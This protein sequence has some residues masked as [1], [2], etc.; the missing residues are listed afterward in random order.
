MPYNGSGDYSAP[1]N[2]FNPAVGGTTISS[3]DWNSLLSDLETALSSVVTKDGQTVITA[4]LPMSGFKHTGVNTNSGSTSR[5]EYASG[6]TLQDGAPLDAGDTGGTSTVYTATLT[7]AITAYANKQCFRVKFNAACG[8]N[9]TI[10][11]NSV[12]AKKIYK[13]VAGTAIQLAASDVYANTIGVLRYDTALD[14]AAGG[15][16]LL[17]ITTNVTPEIPNGRLTLTSN[18]PIT[19]SSITAATSVYFTPYNGT[20]I[21]LYNGSSWSQFSLSQLTLALDSNSGHTGYQQSGKN[22]D[23]FVVNDSGTLRLGTGP[24]WSSDTSR[25]TGAGTTELTLQNGFYVNANSMTL[26]Y[27]SANGDTLTAAVGT[28][29]YVGTMR[30]SANGQT[31][32]SLSNRFVWNAFNRAC[33]PMSVFESTDSWNYTTAAYRQAN[34]STANQFSFVRGLDEDCA[35]AHVLAGATNS[36]GLTAVSVNIGLDSVTT[37]V[38]GN[39]TGWQAAGSTAITPLTSDYIGYPGLGYHYLAWIEYSTAAGTTTWYGDNGNGNIMQ[40]GMKGSVWA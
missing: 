2:S 6:A 27:G 13:N 29:L 22:F 5:S 20:T 1:A 31:E 16:W 35:Q 8:N 34:N 11:F 39:L 30:A 18:V 12:G 3:A 14:G 37:P 40:S 24:A 19:T 38:A 26:R 4:N 9:P 17:N 33:R 21:Y 10:N 25:G 15:F 23:L 28:A 36:G 7:P 32:D